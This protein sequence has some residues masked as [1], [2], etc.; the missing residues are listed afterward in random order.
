[1]G[2]KFTCLGFTC[3]MLL[4]VSIVQS[5]VLAADTIKKE[6]EAADSISAP[7][8]I[9]DDDPL[10]SA[11]RYIGTDEGSGDQN[12]NP[13]ATGVATYSFTAKGGVYKI[14]F[15]VSI[16]SGSNSFWVRI[17]GAT[18]YTP[19]T[20]SS[21]WIRFNDIQ[22]GAAW[23]WDEVHSND[24][25]NQ[26]VQ[27]T[28]PAGNHTL[29]IARREDGAKLDGFVITD[30]LSLNQA[31][32][33]DV[34]DP[35]PK[36]WSP[37]PA[38]G[39]IGVLIPLLQWK[40]GTT[41][42]LHNVYLRTT[43][44][45]TSADLV[46]ANYPAVAYFHP[47]G[48][49]PG[50][51]YYWRVDEIEGNLT[52]IHTGNV[53]SFTSAP[54]TAYLPVPPDGAGYQNGDVD[55]AW[56]PGQ[57][58]FTHEVY[59]SVNK[60][61]VAN[62]AAGALKGAVNILS[63]ELPPLALETTYYWRVDEIDS[64]NNKTVGPVWSF[65]TRPVIAKTANL[66]GWWK[67]EDENSGTAVDYSGWDADGTLNG[68]P[69]W[70][71]GYYGQALQLD[72]RD[73]F[74]EISNVGISGAA[75]RTITG[76]AK[77]N[78]ISIANWTDVFG[79][80]GPSGNGGHFD[81]ERRDY[82]SYALH[83]YGWERDLIPVDLEW[84][85]FAATYDGTNAV[86]YADGVAIGSEPVTL[87]TGA[88][89]RMGKRV[90]TG[91]F[92]PGLVDDVRL[93]DKALSLDE[94]KQTMRGDPSQAWDPQPR[95]GS[96]VDI[97]DAESLSWS[98]GE[99]AAQH[100][101]YFGKDK[102]AVAAAG[103]NALEYKGRQPGTSY[104]IA[105]LVEF[106]GGVYFWRIDEVEADGTTVHRGSV[107]SF[108]V[109]DYLL[110]DDFESYV[111]EVEGRIFQTWIDGWG[112]TEPAPGNPGNGTG[113]TVGY[114]NPPFAE[115][116]IVRSGGQSMPL[117]YSN[118]DAPNYSEAE[119]TFGSPQNWTL[120]GMNTLSLQVRGYPAVTGVAVTE[121]GGKMTLTGDG[122]DIWDAYDDFVFAYKSLN[123][124]ATIVARVTNI[125]TGTNTWAKAGVM[126]RDSLD[127][128]SVF[129]MMVMTDNRDGTANNGASFQWRPTAQSATGLGNT[130]ST[131]VV[132]PPY[133]VKL[134]RA[135]DTFTGYISADG[136][137]WT[138]VGSQDVVMTAPAYVGICVTSHQAG[139]QRTFQFEGIKTTG[140]VTGAWQ[141]AQINSPRYNSV[142]DLYVAIADST[143][144][145]AVVKDAAVVNATVWTEV[146]MPLS[147][148][149]GVSMTKVKKIFIG[150]GDRTNPVA[151]GSGMLFIDDIR[152]IKE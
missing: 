35:G 104:S 60:D 7:M 123:G 122:R 145:I 120:N 14:L 51:T 124:D 113:S 129:A 38:D 128:G 74:V 28:L 102:N 115:R 48:F 41:A 117:G 77:A 98:A 81:I 108:T 85:H 87:N 95:R 27:I 94:I 150:V 45:L 138:M 4:A 53:W 140:S 16:S 84:H 13:P 42:L 109:P 20:H 15:R 134:E 23:H 8:K 64:A 114:V 73:D 133:W 59:F 10:A 111:D 78:T 149:T 80:S 33:P 54:L 29:E 58:A 52:T 137:A 97:R 100:D 151:D 40:P 66:L 101:V 26:V 47:P 148:F 96:T 11:G 139:E 142:Q 136:N 43:P 92:F 1:M 57:N 9:Y 143:N 62:G 39:A 71:D 22:D 126:I 119:R 12:S 131:A 141:G 24:H 146:K 147:S 69:Q 132:K 44:E 125:G 75:A 21:G 18:K 37:S 55:L 110:V 130:G 89:F 83:I 127:G 3:A 88:T 32:L 121:T 56:T 34:I 93:Y 50:T 68:N 17:P 91:G 135:G 99:K 25:S 72:G 79:F 2:K 65:T 106:G 86:R 36:A 90:D 46:S 76:W 49:M 61:D 30:N 105:G 118:A 5:S 19:G 103:T 152:V 63:L 6:A 116:T 112:Y 31:T 70:V 107:W 82:S 67:L 144:K